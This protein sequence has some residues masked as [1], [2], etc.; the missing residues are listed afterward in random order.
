MQRSRVR[1]FDS[2][3]HCNHHATGIKDN[4]RKL[5]GEGALRR[6][7][8][9]ANVAIRSPCAG[10]TIPRFQPFGVE[11][12]LRCKVRS[13]WISNPKDDAEEAL[14]RDVL[15]LSAGEFLC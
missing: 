10:E 2:S 14:E 3:S 13:G 11:I 4:M 15:V 12:M 1:L 7:A 6:F 8:G 5:T 9:L